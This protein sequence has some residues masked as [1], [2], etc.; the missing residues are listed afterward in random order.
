M[1]ALWRI[2]FCREKLATLLNDNFW[3]PEISQKSVLGRNRLTETR[4]PN[5]KLTTLLKIQFWT[6][7]ISQKSVLGRN[8]VTETQNLKSRV[9]FLP[10]SGH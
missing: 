2:D 6:P 10:K 9:V 4:N 3:T 7:K 1:E 8:R 5:Q